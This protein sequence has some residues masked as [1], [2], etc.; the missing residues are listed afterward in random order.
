MITAAFEINTMY[1]IKSTMYER[2]YGFLEY[3]NIPLVINS[4]FSPSLTPILQD[5]FMVMSAK[6]AMIMFNT[7]KQNPAVLKNGYANILIG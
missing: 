1:A 3:P 5:S 4:V 2:K 7:N 6:Q